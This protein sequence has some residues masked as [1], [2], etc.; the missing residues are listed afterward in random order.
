MLAGSVIGFAVAVELFGGTSCTPDKPTVVVHV[1]DACGVAVLVAV[2]VLVGVFVGT[3][4]VLVGVS[5]GVLVDVFVGVQNLFDQTYFVG[6]LP[7]TIGT[8]ASKSWPP[9]CSPCSW[10]SNAT[11]RC[12]RTRNTHP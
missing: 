11:T 10:L 7:T 9:R 5:V 12:G 6:L 4:G 2:A 8:P 3:V 1:G